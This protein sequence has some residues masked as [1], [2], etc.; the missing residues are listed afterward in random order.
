[1]QPTI[2][3]LLAVFA[4][5]F[6]AFRLLDR[7]RS[8]ERR[9]TAFRRGFWTDVAYWFFTPLVGETVKRVALLAVVAPIAYAVWRRVDPA[10]VMGG[11]GPLSRLPLVVQAAMMLVIGDF[12]GYWM[13]RRFHRGWPWRFH[14]VHHSSVDLDWLSSLRVH[15]LNEALMA[16]AALTPILALGFAPIAY[17]AIAPL[18]TL[19][20]LVNHANVDWDW[21]P[22]RTVIA[23]PRFHRWHHSAEPEALNKNFAGFFP[24]WDILFGTYYMPAGRAPR[25]FGADLP[26]PDGLWRQLTFPFRRNPAPPA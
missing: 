7:T 8:R 1:M 14:A 16:M 26:V 4:I 20:A 23:S 21:G 24:L 9:L 22:L 18:V 11:F 17:A 25:V 19:L 13:H 12:V 6:V 3:K 15:P 5:L 2:P 10:L